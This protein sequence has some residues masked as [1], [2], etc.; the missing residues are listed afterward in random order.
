MQQFPTKRLTV[1]SNESKGI[2]GGGG[3]GSH[4]PTSNASEQVSHVPSQPVQT[5]T[6]ARRQP[7]PGMPGAGASVNA[8]PALSGEALARVARQVVTQGTSAAAKV[9]AWSFGETS[10]GVSPEPRGIPQQRTQMDQQKPQQPQQQPKHESAGDVVVDDGD[11]YAE[12]EFRGGRKAT[13]GTLQEF[14]PRSADETVQQAKQRVLTQSETDPNF[15]SVALPSGFHLYRDGLQHLSASIVRGR[16]QAKF[17]RA[18]KEKNSAYLIEGVTSLLGDGVSALRLTTGDFYWLL[19]WLLLASYPVRSRAL[20][21]SCGD[22][23]HLSAVEDGTLPEETLRTLITYDKPKL[24]EVVLDKATLD[25]LDLSALGGLRLGG[26]LVRDMV[27]WE[28]E[29]EET[30]TEED[31]SIYDLAV[32]LADGTLEE[33]AD[34]VRDMTIEQ[35]DA[36]KAYKDVAG[37]H[38]VTAS[39]NCICKEC[40]AE[41]EV[42]LSISARDFL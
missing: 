5:A 42:T 40:G 31:Y 23:K 37:E 18:A 33:R 36:L 28:T 29:Y 4:R 20:T 10:Q 39:L 25:N 26:F 6:A 1:P 11:E 7:H 35:I 2:G 27:E 12:E 24:S 32:Y 9:D 34:I 3:G 38:G 14:A 17:N 8:S 19:Y 41:K 22:E 16:H 13:P 15:Y 30:A 21:Y